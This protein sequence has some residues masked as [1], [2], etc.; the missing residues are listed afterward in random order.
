MTQCI[1]FLGSFGRQI[2][3][4]V[5]A[6]ILAALP[7]VAQGGPGG[8]GGGGGGGETTAVNN[9]SFP[10]I[11]SCGV[12][13]PL[14]GTPGVEKFLG[15]YTVIAGVNWYHQ[16]DANNSW[17]AE[18]LNYRINST[19]RLPVSWVDWSDNLESKDWYVTSV[20][21]VETVLYR[22]LGAP[23]TL[24]VSI[25][26]MTTYPMAYLYGDGPTE[27]QGTNGFEFPG[28][29]A[30]IYT[31]CSRF[32][33]QKIADTGELMLYWNGTAWAGDSLLKTLFNKAT[34][35]G[36]DGR[37]AYSGEINVGGKLI[38]GYNWSVSRLARDNGITD[39]AGRYRLTFSIDP[40]CT[41]TPNLTFSYPYTKILTLAPES[42]AILAAEPGGGG[43]AVIDYNNQLT[44]IDVR[45]LPRG[46]GGGGGGGPR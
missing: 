9:L 30:T 43:K 24:G 37:N 39:P 21:R 27:M 45:I 23:D 34:Y 29:Q 18:S 22:D 25:A 11:W 12:T 4:V 13:K 40:G 5:T 32:T 7:A 3:P 20:V 26:P 19:R 31:S 36:G 15:D 33:L 17:Q 1:H 38:Y 14:P 6:V 2:L 42:A 41:V 35:E 46:G 8:G 16:Q 28:S 44:Y 10:V